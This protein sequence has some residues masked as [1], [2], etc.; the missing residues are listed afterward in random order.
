MKFKTEIGAADFSNQGKKII[1]HFKDPESLEQAF[2]KLWAV[3]VFKTAEIKRPSN[4][5]PE[6]DIILDRGVIGGY[7]MAP[8]PVKLTEITPGITKCR[9]KKSKIAEA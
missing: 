6:C 7:Y 2:I 9:C 5:M 3:G 1:Y 4:I 8:P